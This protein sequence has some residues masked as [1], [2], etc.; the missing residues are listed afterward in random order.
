MNDDVKTLAIVTGLII[1]ALMLA[2]LLLSALP[3]WADA[4]IEKRANDKAQT[5]QAQ[6][7]AAIKYASVRQMDMATQ[8]LEND[9]KTANAIPYAVI[10]ALALALVIVCIIAYNEKRIAEKRHAE[11]VDLLRQA[12][13]VQSQHFQAV[14][15]GGE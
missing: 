8:A 6:A 10:V 12:T 9:V 7:D 1:A 3:G 2:C 13:G 5:I 4:L 15:G 14:A 11:L